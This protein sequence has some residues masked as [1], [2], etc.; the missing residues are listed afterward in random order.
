[1]TE[2]NNTAAVDEMTVAVAENVKDVGA[3]DFYQPRAITLTNTIKNKEVE[4]THKSTAIDDEIWLEFNEILN[5]RRE[6]Q[7][8]KLVYKDDVRLAVKAIYKKLIPEIPEGYQQFFKQTLTPQ[9]FCD[10]VPF[11]DQQAVLEQIF[12]FDISESDADEFFFDGDGANRFEI[13]VPI[14]GVIQTGTIALNGKTK[15]SEKDYK[16][17]VEPKSGDVKR[18]RHVEVSVKSDFAKLSGVF[19]SLLAG[20]ENFRTGVPVWMRVGLMNYYFAEF[21]VSEAKN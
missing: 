13:D 11:A 9:N 3:V 2:E 8:K 4:F 10:L 5:P 15:Q 6:L 17:A 14:N 18:F 20:A 19:D 12:A 1:M 16:R 7:N 21:A